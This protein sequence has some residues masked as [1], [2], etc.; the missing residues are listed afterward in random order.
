MF[1]LFGIFLTIFGVFLF[2]SSCFKDW[3]AALGILFSILLIFVGVMGTL[4][5]FGA[6][7]NIVEK[8]KAIDVYRE[9]TTLE[10]TYRDSVAVDTTVV[11]KDK[12]KPKK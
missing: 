4:Q 9:K 2:I 8:P 3:E 6:F 1:A 5:E 11:W 7:D 12:F 10:I